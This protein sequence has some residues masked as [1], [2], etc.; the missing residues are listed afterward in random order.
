MV[1]W[2]ATLLE[3][4][5]TMAG[6]PEFG[7]RAGP[8]ILRFGPYELDL[9]AEELR[10]NGIRI[11]LQDQPFQ[12]LR[13]LLENPGQVVQREEIQKRLWPND[14]I[15][16]FDHG[17]NAAV[18]RLRDALHDSA[19]KPRYIE[20]VARRGY[21]FIGQVN[22]GEQA[23]RI[24]TSATA[25][26]G[27]GSV[28]RTEPLVPAPSFP[29]WRNPRILIPVALTLVLAVW[30][31]V[32]DRKRGAL[33]PTL[34]PLM[35]LD[36]ELGTPSPGSHRVSRRRSV[37]EW[38]TAGVRLAVEVVHPATRSGERHRTAGNR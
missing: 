31:G 17:I 13:M 28:S 30:I 32:A 9:G 37:A 7:N 26:P 5:I 11:R 4:G 22:S 38:H 18:R 19:G 8:S 23:G 34:Q 36:V 21:R 3:P 35:R 15:V 2:L 6:T 14:T 12:I 33:S 1:N 16:E 27:N 25:V 20:T 29:F 24:G 10:K